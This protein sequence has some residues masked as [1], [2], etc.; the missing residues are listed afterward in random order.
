M[1]SLLRNTILYFMLAV[2]L[3][4]MNGVSFYV[5]ECSSSNIREVFAFREIFEQKASCCCEDETC[6]VSPGAPILS[7][8]EQEC[9]K[10]SLIYLKAA[11]TALRVISPDDNNEMTSD[12]TADIPGFVP[13]DESCT[14]AFVTPVVYHPPPLAG[15]SLVLYLHQI[16]IPVSI[17]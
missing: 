16:K 15:R 8:S 2:F 3:A 6:V 13:F 4:G 14:A 1:K 9:C 17:S 7:L 12:A 10:S 5:H 11:I